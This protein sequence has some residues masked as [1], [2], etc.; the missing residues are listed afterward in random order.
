MAE[1]GGFK[2]PNR[3]VSQLL[4]MFEYRMRQAVSDYDAGN[5]S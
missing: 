4:S 2:S 1:S 3:F 5:N